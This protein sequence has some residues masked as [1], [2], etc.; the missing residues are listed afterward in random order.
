MS[1]VFTATV[2]IDLMGV[3]GVSA[4]DYTVHWRLFVPWLSVDDLSNIP[5]AA[6]DFGF[7]ESLSWFNSGNFPDLPPGFL[8]AKGGQSIAESGV[9]G[10]GDVLTE[11]S[12]DGTVLVSRVNYNNIYPGEAETD[13]IRA[14]F[15]WILPNHGLYLAARVSRILAPAFPSS[16]AVR[17]GFQL[18]DETDA[19]AIDVDPPV[20]ATSVSGYDRYFLYRFRVGAGAP[21]PDSN[22]WTNFRACV[23]DV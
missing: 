12:N 18:Y 21:P 5:P 15:D 14:A 8:I 11:V 16:E 1:N 3:G 20:I 2:A 17:S 22:F 13:D 4:M 9:A 7:T 23:E 10:G 19:S 6:M